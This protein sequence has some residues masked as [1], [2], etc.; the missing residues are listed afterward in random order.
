[1]TDPSTNDFIATLAGT[2]IASLQQA[3]DLI[4][5][6][7]PDL[8]PKKVVM[9][10]ERQADLAFETSMLIMAAAAADYEPGDRLTEIKAVAATLPGGEVLLAN[11]Q[12][13]RQ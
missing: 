7:H 3:I 1:M 12:P 10:A 13:H 4:A 6:T 9:E 2:Y 11:M 5:T 8:S